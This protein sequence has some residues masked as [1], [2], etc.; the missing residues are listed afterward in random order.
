MTKTAD[1]GHPGLQISESHLVEALQTEHLACF[2]RCRD[3]VAEFLYDG[4]GFHDLFGVTG[5][6]PPARDAQIVF[7][8]DADVAAEQRRMGRQ[9]HLEPTGAQNGPVVVCAEEAV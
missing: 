5:R 8:A 4:P 7:E 1:A 3:V 6:K 2:G 9:R